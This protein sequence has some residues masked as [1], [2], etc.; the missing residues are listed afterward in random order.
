M[1]VTHH[2]ESANGPALDR[3]EAL[4]RVGGD[5]DLLR[6]IAAV[7]LDDCPNSLSQLRDAVSNGDARL[8]ERQAHTLKGSIATFGTGNVFETARKIEL[9]GRCGDL[10]EVASDLIHLEAG[11]ETL[12]ADLRSFINE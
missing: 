11:L 12:K 7:F 5:V 1:S 2:S 10:T 6:E 3:E 8:V 9:Q 4:S